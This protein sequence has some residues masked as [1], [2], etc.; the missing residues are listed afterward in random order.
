MLREWLPSRSWTS[1]GAN[2][3]IIGAYRF[4]DPAGEVGIETFLIEC[5]DGVL[6]VPATYRAAPLEEADASLITTMKHSV[7]GRRWVYDAAADPV[8]VRALA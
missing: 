4:D 3:R 5:S 1:D 8:Y 7:L 6:Q 2:I